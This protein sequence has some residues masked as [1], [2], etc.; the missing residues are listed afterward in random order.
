MGRSSGESDGEQ[1]DED[2]MMLEPPPGKF[3]LMISE[4]YDLVHE[5]KHLN[6][7]K[8]SEKLF[9]YCCAKIGGVFQNNLSV[10]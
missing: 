1:D 6:L 10:K 4:I 9:L 5:Q 8:G 3:F 2:H 7:L